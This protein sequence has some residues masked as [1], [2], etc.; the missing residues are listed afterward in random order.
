MTLDLETLAEKTDV[1]AENVKAGLALV[2]VPHKQAALEDLKQRQQEAITKQDFKKLQSIGGDIKKIEQKFMPWQELHAASL[3]LC[4][5]LAL[6]RTESK[7][8]ELLSAAELEFKKLQER[9]HSLH[10]MSLFTADDDEAS[11]YMSIHAGAGGAEA[12]DWAGMLQRMYVRYSERKQFSVSVVDVLPERTAGIK[13]ATLHIKGLYAC[14]LLKAEVGVHRLVRIS[15]FDAGKRRHT[16]FA[17]VSVIPEID[18]TIEF[19]I[20]PSDVRI[21]TFRASGAGGQHV[22]TTDSAVRI[23]HLPSKIVV[24][25]QVE[26]SQY[27]NKEQAF[28][29]LKARLYERHREQQLANSQKQ[30]K[31]QKKIEWGSQIRSYILHPYQLIKD[32]RTGHEVGDVKSVMDGAIN[33][34]IEAYLKYQLQLQL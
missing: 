28:K 4:S 29:I 32:H 11:A 2:N 5:L 10:V 30:K 23:T 16:S 26:R 9:Y 12:C 18:E 7:R 8:E 3:E 21:D 20:D 6:I 14:G 17:S 1:L 27:Q 24:S 19:K 13:S 33:D 31:L 15:P 25:C 34:F 22:N